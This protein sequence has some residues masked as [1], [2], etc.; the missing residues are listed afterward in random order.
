MKNKFVILLIFILVM[1]FV[2]VGAV[3]YWVS[4]TRKLAEN[5]GKHT[6]VPE[7][8][9]IKKYEDFILEGRENNGRIREIELDSKESSYFT[10]RLFKD[11]DFL[12]LPAESPLQ[13]KNVLL[14]GQGDKLKMEAV[15]E[16]SD[17]VSAGLPA[18][19]SGAYGL[20]A[21]FDIKAVDTGIAVRP[22]S[23][24]I[25]TSSVP[26]SILMS[27]VKSNP[28]DTTVTSD[29]YIIIPSMELTDDSG[30][31]VGTVAGLEVK[32]GKLVFKLK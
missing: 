29:G 13:T 31:N 7:E 5:F 25:G 21:L 23:L 24:E 20:N 28:G 15:I 14:K 19:M 4:G 32:D 16:I 1:V 9:E 17:P 8:K 10:S 2:S 22:V 6:E 27:V 18:N 11:T 30:R 3:V 12:K 26:V